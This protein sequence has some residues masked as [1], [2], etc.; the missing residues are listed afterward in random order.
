MK[1]P[2]APLARMALKAITRLATAFRRPQAA[3][4]APKPAQAPPVRNKAIAEPPTH[5]PHCG[6]LFIKLDWKQLPW[7]RTGLINAARPLIYHCCECNKDHERQQQNDPIASALRRIP[8]T[9]P[10][11]DSWHDCGCWGCHR[12][13]V[14]QICAKSLRVTQQVS[15]DGKFWVDADS[16]LSAEG[17]PY[18]RQRQL[19]D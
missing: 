8:A 2:L 9:E 18:L 1:N 5:C 19:E 10:L 15:L 14:D 16:L 6:N 12:Q 3:Q 7:L 17:F 13:R 11:H 4:T